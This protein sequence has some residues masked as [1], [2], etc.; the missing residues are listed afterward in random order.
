MK[1]GTLL[2]VLAAAAAVVA[3]MAAAPAKAAVADPQL[4]IS[5]SAV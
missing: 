1:V 4:A 3:I 2:G 5:P